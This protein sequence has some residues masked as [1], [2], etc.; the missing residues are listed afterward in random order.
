[1]PIFNR[2]PRSLRTLWPDA[3]APL[4]KLVGEMLDKHPE[5]R[6]KAA[7]IVAHLETGE[8]LPDRR[9]LISTNQTLA[10]LIGSAL[11]P[12]VS[13]VSY[14]LLAKPPA[15]TATYSQA[16]PPPL[17]P[18]EIAALASRTPN[19]MVFIPPTEFLMGETDQQAQE[20]HELCVDTP[21]RSKLSC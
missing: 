15:R 3:P 8:K 21:H 16:E 7:E 11:L 14:V 5:Y 10:F 20:A 13:S 18:A 1:M 12:S 17:S 6:P 4:V 19:G 2:A 9:V